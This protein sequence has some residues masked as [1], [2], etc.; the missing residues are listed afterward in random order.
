MRIKYDVT[1]SII[2]SYLAAHVLPA[3]PCTYSRDCS[4]SGNDCSLRWSA[5]RSQSSEAPDDIALSQFRKVL[6]ISFYYNVL[7]S[8]DERNVYLGMAQYCS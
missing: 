1:I 2:S 6:K 3:L 4:P 7:S 5:R 8:P